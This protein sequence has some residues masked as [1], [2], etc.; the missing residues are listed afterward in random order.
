MK[1]VALVNIWQRHM[2]LLDIEVFEVLCRCPTDRRLLI[3]R[4]IQTLL[5][6]RLLVHDRTRSCRKMSDRFVNGRWL[7]AHYASSSHRGGSHMIREYPL[8][9]F[10]A[11]REVA[12]VSQHIL[13]EPLVL[14]IVHYSLSL[15]FL[16]FLLL[17]LSFVNDPELRFVLELAVFYARCDDA[18]A[19][20]VQERSYIF[21]RF[22]K[23]LLEFL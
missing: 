23:F 17:L 15:L 5:V 1:D 14:E 16:S 21:S 7:L 3:Q 11:H 10:V 22:A 6:C 19:C 9:Y 12:A 20:S 13:G 2:P 18:W 8:V 4:Q